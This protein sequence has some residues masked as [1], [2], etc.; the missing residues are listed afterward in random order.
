VGRRIFWL[1]VI[2]GIAYWLYS[3]RGS[4]AGGSSSGSTASPTSYNRDCLMLAEQANRGLHDAAMLLAKM[5]VD[6]SAWNSAEGGVSQKISD[7]ESKCT[8]GANDAEREYQKEINEALQIMKRSLSGFSSA[9]RGAGGAI[10][11]AQLQ[12]QIDQH[13]DRARSVVGLP[14]GP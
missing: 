10:D 1:V 4:T 12:E 6:A 5:P 9:S 3:H 2:G 7:A 13:L 14:A 8:G 11:A